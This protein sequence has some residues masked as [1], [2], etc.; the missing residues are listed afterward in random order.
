MD[1]GKVSHKNTN[2][3]T[4]PHKEKK[5]FHPKNLRQRTEEEKHDEERSCRFTETSP[6]RRRHNTDDDTEV[7]DYQYHPLDLPPEA[8]EYIRE[9]VMDTEEYFPNKIHNLKK[10][11]HTRYVFFSVQ[12]PHKRL[13]FASPEKQKIQEGEYD[14]LHHPEEYKNTSRYT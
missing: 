2:F 3:P 11:L 14:T 8:N 13:Y 9:Y 1:T 4:K 5:E 6:E 12:Y 10:F 7:S